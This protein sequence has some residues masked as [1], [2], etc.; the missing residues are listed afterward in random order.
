MGI[1]IRIALDST[2]YIPIDLILC[3]DINFFDS[4][5]RI[6]TDHIAYL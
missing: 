6:N 2:S 1:H 5:S 4:K 3:G